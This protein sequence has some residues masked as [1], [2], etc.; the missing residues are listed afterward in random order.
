MMS[1]SKSGVEVE[2]VNTQG[3][4]AINCS[5]TVR[6]SINFLNVTQYVTQNGEI[7]LF[8]YRDNANRHI[9]LL[10]CS[11]IVLYYYTC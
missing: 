3:K 5:F 2:N 8:L 6:E 9:L 7:V 10:E 1:A 11:V 4:Y